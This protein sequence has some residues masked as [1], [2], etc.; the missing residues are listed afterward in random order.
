MLIE[1]L[2]SSLVLVEPTELAELEWAVVALAPARP[3]PWQYACAMTSASM[4]ISTLLDAA[5]AQQELR[6]G[7]NGSERERTVQTVRTVRSVRSVREEA[8]R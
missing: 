3:W 1:V 2:P 7:A 6:T 5:A 8:R 4:T